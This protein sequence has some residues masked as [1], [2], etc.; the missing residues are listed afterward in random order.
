[1]R[2]LRFTLA[3]GMGL[4]WAGLSGASADTLTIGDPAPPL[5]VSKWV[6]G[7]KFDKL[8]PGQTYV[9]EFWATWCG[10][11]RASIPHLTELQKEYRDKG[12]KFIGVSVWEQDQSRVEPFVKEMGDKM[13]YSVA[14][15]DVPAGESRQKGKMAQAWMAAA[16]EN[17]IPTAFVV[18]K[19]KI[20]WIG[21][22]MEMDK[23]LD[24]IVSGD[25]DLSAAATERRESKAAEQKT[26]AVFTTL[27]KH[28]RAKEYKQALEVLDK[29]IADDPALER[30]VGPTKFEM[31]L[32]TGASGSSEYGRKLVDGP[33][34]DQAMPLNNLAWSIVDPDNG[35][36]TSRRDVK[37]ALQAAERANELTNG[38]NYAILDTLAKCCF[39]SGN[40]ARALELQEKAVR[41]APQ[42]DPE[43][44]ARLEQYR[45]AA[46]KAS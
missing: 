36:E 30:Q 33:L 17:G 46:K 32:K 9:V 23:P 5:T 43:M 37:L 1:M 2:M 3:A 14:M 11:C 28:L 7:E 16:E 13:N 21:H 4:L 27:A 18:K 6:K 39:D 45:K 8:D 24:K 40:P 42:E 41:R 31:M 29:A 20:A 12:V 44:K 15:D 22:P 10:P 38:D 34:K 35:L 26:N 25:Y 19:G